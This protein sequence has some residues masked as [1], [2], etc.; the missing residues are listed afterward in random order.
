MATDF[1]EQLAT[2]PEARQAG[3][4][5]ERLFGRPARAPAGA[6]NS[7]VP[8]LYHAL[9]SRLLDWLRLPHSAGGLR[10]EWRPL[11]ALERG[12]DPHYF[13]EH[14]IREALS[15]CPPI[16]EEARAALVATLTGFFELRRSGLLEPALAS[17]LPS[18]ALEQ[19]WAGMF[20]AR[21][22]WQSL[23]ILRDVGWYPVGSRGGYRAAQRFEHGTFDPGLTPDSLRSWLALC[24]RGN[25]P[26]AGLAQVPE[27]APA[28]PYRAD[29]LASAFAG[30]LEALGLPGTCGEVPHC[31]RCPLRPDCRWAARA[32]AGSATGRQPQADHGHPPEAN[33]SALELQATTRIGGQ[34][35]LGAA[36]LLQGVFGLE[37]AP[38]AKLQERL[39]DLPLRSLA[40][41][42]VPQLEEWLD[43]LP[44]GAE[45]LTLLMELSRRFSE[46][47]MRPGMVF[48]TGWDVFKHFR[49]R[50]RD[51]KQERLIIV[52]LDIKR[53]YL[54]DVE[55]TQGGLDTSPVHP[56]EVFAPAIQ[57]RAA[58]VV[59]VHNHPSGDPTPSR[60]DLQSTR[61]LAEVGRL[62]GIPVID[63]VIIADDKYTSVR[64]S[65]LIEL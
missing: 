32:G 8:L 3:A 24:W 63:H 42:S 52:L 2:L 20:P 50:L 55:I 13:T 47:P 15:A 34:Q 22:A 56:R 39:A 51:L 29:L 38:T 30:E 25:P 49:I 54:G 14:Q 43:G 23:D 28:G 65:G 26:P 4:A 27:P 57:R 58:G 41:M 59:L 18:P 45:R 33:Y 37:A 61:A 11:F 62:V 21:L 16:H 7:A 31:E 17:G 6:P 60:D 40:A 36:Q 5:F 19:R 35:A 64:E 10:W 48:A 53:R 9:L 46:E 44:P 1:L 12:T